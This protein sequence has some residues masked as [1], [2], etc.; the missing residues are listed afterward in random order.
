LTRA[1]PGGY[2]AKRRHAAENVVL[3]E[4]IEYEWKELETK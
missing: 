1:A 3:L 4:P 2:T